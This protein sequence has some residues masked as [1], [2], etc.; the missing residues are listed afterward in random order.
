MM[1]PPRRL[2]GQDRRHHRYLPDDR[3]Q[4]PAAGGV[5][6]GRPPPLAEFM[7]ASN[8]SQLEPAVFEPT[9]HQPR[10][11]PL[12]TP[13]PPPPQATNEHTSDENRYGGTRDAIARIWREEG[14]GG[15]FAG[16]REKILQTVR[17]PGGG[18][19]WL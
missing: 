15:F 12:L 14:A 10:Q 18:L 1:Q 5:Y 8:P 4:E 13:P 3:G 2:P 9:N 11:P 19:D 17:F 6:R 7:Q 16:L